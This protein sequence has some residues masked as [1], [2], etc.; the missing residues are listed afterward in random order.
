MLQRSVCHSVVALRT[1][2]KD[3]VEQRN[4]GPK[5]SSPPPNVGIERTVP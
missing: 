4:Q 3:V 5:P 1:A 2:I